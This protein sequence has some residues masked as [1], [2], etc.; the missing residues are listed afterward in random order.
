MMGDRTRGATV[1]LDRNGTLIRD[2]G[3]LRRADQV[4]ILPRVPAALRL[5]HD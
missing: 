5:L 2:V 4:E 1:F 3:Y